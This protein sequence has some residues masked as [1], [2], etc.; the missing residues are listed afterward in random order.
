MLGSLVAFSSVEGVARFVLAHLPHGVPRLAWN[1]SPDL[2]VWGYSLALTALTGI[3]FV[4]AR[5]LHATRQD[6]STAMRSG[7]GG[8]GGKGASGE[9]LRSVLVGVQVAVCMVLLIAAGLLMRGLYL[10]QT[11]DPGFEMSGITQ[12]VFDLPSQGYN[13]ERA[14]AFQGELL[15]RVATLPGVDAVE[16]AHVTPLSHQFLGTGFTLEGETK[17]RQFEFNVVSAGYFAMLGMPIMRGRTFTAAETR[18]NA[19][20]LVV[21]ESTARKLWPG[22]DAI[23]KT[24]RGWEKKVYQVVGVVRDSQ[25]SHLGQ[26]DGLFFYVPAGTGKA[27]PVA[28]L[29]PRQGGGR[30]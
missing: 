12:A 1:V 23:G 25:A 14:Q 28:I 17:T 26:S 21:T 16:Q 4:L 11:V 30:G 15:A 18:S 29:G 2:H 5:A 22:Q 7:G 19:Q 24:L 8:F 20:V 10:A 6:L 27:K 13:R 9:M 3:V